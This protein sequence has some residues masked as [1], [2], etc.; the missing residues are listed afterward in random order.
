MLYDCC[1]TTT[2]RNGVYAMRSILSLAAW[3][4]RMARRPYAILCA[5]FV[6]G[7]RILWV[8]FV[9]PL[10]PTFQG[11]LLVYPASW[12]AAGAAVTVAYWAL[13]RKLLTEKPPQA[14]V[15]P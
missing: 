6:C 14:P 9:F 1:N 3:N 12:L 13:K 8:A 2:K 15:V 5:V 11:L 7:L 10:M 4:W